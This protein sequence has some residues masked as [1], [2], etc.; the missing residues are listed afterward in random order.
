VYTLFGTPFP[1]FLS[2]LVLYIHCTGGFIMPILDSLTLY[3][4]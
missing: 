3:I 2:F 1:P 4:G